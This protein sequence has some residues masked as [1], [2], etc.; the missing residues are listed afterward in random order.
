MFKTTL[1][2]SNYFNLSKKENKLTHEIYYTLNFI[3]VLGKSFCIYPA[4]ERNNIT[5]FANAQLAS[6]RCGIKFRK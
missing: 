1:F 6:S 2:L 4:T 3:I 5:T